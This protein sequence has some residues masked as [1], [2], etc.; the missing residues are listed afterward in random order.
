MSI[1]LDGQV[2]IFDEAHNMEDCCR[3]AASAS[4]KVD[5]IQ[6]ALQDCE[7]VGRAGTETY[8]HEE[9]VGFIQ[10]FSMSSF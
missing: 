6:A 4:L 3:D 9:L 5:A 10:L 1:E 2:V 7:R 8:A